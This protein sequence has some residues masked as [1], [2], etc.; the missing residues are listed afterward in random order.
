MTAAVKRHQRAETTGN[1]A[2]TQTSFFSNICSIIVHVC[3]IFLS[4][5]LIYVAR[6]G[7]CNIFLTALFSWHPT[8]MTLAFILCMTEA[9]SLFSSTKFPINVPTYPNKVAGHQK[10]QLAAGLLTLLGTSTIV[11][12]KYRSNS[13]H[14][15]SY[16]SWYG[17][18]TLILTILQTLYGLKM[19]NEMPVIKYNS[20]SFHLIFG[21]T[22]YFSGMT[23]I[24]LA[25][26]SNWAVY[27]IDLR[28]VMMLKY[29]L[30]ALFIVVVVNVFVRSSKKYRSSYS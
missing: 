6:P 11:F 15:V 21:L 1:M 22:T 9:I 19:V 4:A 23:T 13:N 30:I 17:L 26:Y 14:L 2:T 25:F 12:N 20:K 24:Y 29:S 28:L 27:V 10:M 5:S 8:F 16:H 3:V 18:A 7:S